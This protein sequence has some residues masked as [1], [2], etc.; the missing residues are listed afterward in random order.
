[1]LFVII[2]VITIFQFVGQKRWVHYDQ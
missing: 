1:V 2:L